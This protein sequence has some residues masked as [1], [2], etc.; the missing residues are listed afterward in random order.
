MTSPLVPSTGESFAVLTPPGSSASEMNCSMNKARDT[1]K[2]QQL[3]TVRLIR[4]RFKMF[5]CPR[6]IGSRLT[7]I[8][9]S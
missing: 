9:S 5:H 7:Y 2:D 8:L 6:Q 3:V 4:K 1:A